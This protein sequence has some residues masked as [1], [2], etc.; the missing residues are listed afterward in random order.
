MAWHWKPAIEIYIQLPI[1]LHKMKTVILII[2][3]KCIII[4][5]SIQYYYYYYYYYLSDLFIK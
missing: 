5:S 2:V 3:T 4:S 1:K